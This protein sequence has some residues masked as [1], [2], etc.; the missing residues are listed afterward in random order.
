[1]PGVLVNS[2]FTLLT[3]CVDL[4]LLILNSIVAL[5]FGLD[6]FFC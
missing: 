1:M 6:M 5:V 4:A 2:R 3:C